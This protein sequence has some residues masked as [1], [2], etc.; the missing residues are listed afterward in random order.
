M[1]GPSRN[2]PNRSEVELLDGPKCTFLSKAFGFRESAGREN[3]QTFYFLEK[4][5][6]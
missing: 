6:P 1:I 3:L 5:K 2:V 4:K